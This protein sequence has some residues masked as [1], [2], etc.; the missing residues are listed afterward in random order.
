MRDTLQK[1]LCSLLSNM[2]VRL[3][4]NAV[5][6]C[7]V[8]L[9]VIV[10]KKIVCATLPVYMKVALVDTVLHPTEMHVHSFGFAL[11]DGAMNYARGAGVI[12]LDGC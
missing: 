8:M 10:T 11:S 7:W 6:R 2:D 1:R 12:S 3:V 4:H 9:G 5:V